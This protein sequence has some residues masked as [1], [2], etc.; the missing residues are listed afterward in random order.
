MSNAGRKVIRAE[1]R[2]FGPYDLE[3]PLQESFGLITLTYDKAKG[4]GTYLMR[5]TPGGETIAHE[6]QGFEDFLILEGEL[7]DD[8]GT[9]LKAGDLISYP[10]GSHHNSRS[11]I[12]CTILV[13]E[14]KASGG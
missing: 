2:R 11:E 9:V 7:I 3:G 13:T 4:E 5:I 6:H 12:G 14:W 8:D 1:E 10:P